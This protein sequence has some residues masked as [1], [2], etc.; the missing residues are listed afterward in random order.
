ML[1]QLLTQSCVV[2]RKLQS[3]TRDAY[4]N[5][6]PDTAT[7]TYPCALQAGIGGITAVLTRVEPADMGE[8]SSG[9]F[10]L[11]LPADAVL[12]TADSVEVEGHVYEVTGE[13][14][15]VWNP[16][17]QKNSHVEATVARV[18]GAENKS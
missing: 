8:L 15:A 3:I 16:R 12:T 10:L 11:F 4:G 7:V 1:S 6:V 17:L 9:K 5:E 13:P 14:T 2:T 18:A